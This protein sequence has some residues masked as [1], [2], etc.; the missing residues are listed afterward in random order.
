MTFVL[1]D[2]LCTSEKT[3]IINPVLGFMQEYFFASL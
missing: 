3:I 1:D 2:C